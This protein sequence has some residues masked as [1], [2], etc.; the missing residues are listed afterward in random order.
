MKTVDNFDLIKNKLLEF[1]KPGDFYVV[2]VIQRMKDKKVAGSVNP[3]DSTGDN[4]RLLKTWYIDSLDYWDTKVPLIK[5]IA[6]A[7]NARAYILPTVR[8]RLTVNRV[9]LKKMVDMIDDTNCRYDHLIRTAVCGCHTSTKPFWIADLDKEMASSDKHK[10]DDDK[11]VWLDVWADDIISDLSRY[12]SETS[13]KPDEIFKVPT[14]NGIHI[15]TPPF[16]RTKW[17]LN[18]DILKKDP[19]TLLYYKQP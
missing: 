8:N 5:E 1:K 16:D 3:G 9:L 6:E 13:R 2:H 4:Q 10:T 7:N 18:P 11:L 15:V 19:M 14:V 12:V 17:P